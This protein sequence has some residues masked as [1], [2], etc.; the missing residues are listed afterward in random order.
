[1]YLN[2]QRLGAPKSSFINTLINST[3]RL[4]V[5][6]TSESSNRPAGRIE[7]LRISASVRYT[8]G[9]YTVLGRFACD[10][11]TRALWHFDEAAGPTAMHDG[12][13]GNGSN[14]GGI[15]NTLTGVN[16][17]STGP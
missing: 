8:G 13:D 12:E 7:E 1:L 2:G 6:G 9:T 5:G 4:Y 14:C 16:G 17:A 10:K 3:G 15:E 11:Q